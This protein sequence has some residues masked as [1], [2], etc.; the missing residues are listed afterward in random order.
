MVS[1]LSLNEVLVL[2]RFDRATLTVAIEN[3]SFPKPLPLGP[4]TTGWNRGEV[5]AWREART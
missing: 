3:D 4:W 2:C 1:T 5:E